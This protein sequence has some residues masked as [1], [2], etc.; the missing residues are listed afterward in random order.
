MLFSFAEPSSA[1]DL[2]GTDDH[3]SKGEEQEGDTESIG[4]EVQGGM[5][6]LRY[7]VPGDILLCFL[8]FIALF[9]SRSIFLQ[10]LSPVAIFGFYILV[11]L[12]S[13]SEITN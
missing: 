1:E 4:E 5:D 13:H 2:V 12:N 7:S 10:L 3:T 11:V 9:T 6:I 8:W